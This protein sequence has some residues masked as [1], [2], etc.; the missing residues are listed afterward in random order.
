MKSIKYML[1]L[2]SFSLPLFIGCKSENTPAEYV[3]EIETF[4]E[5]RIT[6]L[7]KPDGWLSL[8]GLHWLKEGANTFGSHKSNDIVFV[9]KTPA[10]IGTFYLNDSIVTVGINEGVN[11][12][13]DSLPVKEMEISNDF[14]GNPTILTTGSIQWFVIKRSG[15][16][17][18]IRVKDSESELIKNFDGI[19]SF[20]ININWRFEAKYVPYDS[21]KN[22]E[23]PN[24]AYDAEEEKTPGKLVFEKDGTEYSLDVLPSGERYFIIFAD[25]TNGE[26]TYGGG[27]YVYTD[28][29]DSN[30]VVIL[31]FNK[32]YNPPCIFT[33]FATCSLPP[34]DNIL[35]LRIEAG[36]RT[37]GHG[38]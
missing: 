24:A 37:S 30:R 28:K 14:S 4:R 12:F 23:L 10:F 19:N 3:K 26:E 13:S 20:P 16:K 15:G 17:Y 32:A 8:V 25:E 11:V 21:P 2:M 22:I 38:H 35:R 9:D 7:L 18:G 29:A 5:K 31:D 36:E 27:R 6:N 1:M 33:K 34:K